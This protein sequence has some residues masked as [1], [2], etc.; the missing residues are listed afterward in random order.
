VPRESLEVWEWYEK[1][2]RKGSH[3]WESLEK[4]VRIHKKNPSKK[5]WDMISDSDWAQVE[6]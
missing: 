2:V 4:S 3:Y 5:P 1:L 6:T